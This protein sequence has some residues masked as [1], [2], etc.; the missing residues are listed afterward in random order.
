M[1]YNAGRL[2]FVSSIAAL[3]EL[4]TTLELSSLSLMTMRCAGFSGTPGPQDG[5]WENSFS[6]CP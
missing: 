4:H 6:M 1:I 3:F 2:V 5:G